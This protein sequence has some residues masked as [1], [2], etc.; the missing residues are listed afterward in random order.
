MAYDRDPIDPISK[1][2]MQSGDPSWTIRQGEA[3]SYWM[4][5]KIE[6]RLYLYPIPSSITW[7]D[8]VTTDSTELVTNGDFDTDTDWEKSVDVGWTI[9]GGVANCD[10]TQ[11]VAVNIWQECS[12]LVSGNTY[13]VVF[14]VS[15]YVAGNVRVRLGNTGVGTYRSAD[16][17]YT[18]TVTAS[19]TEGTW[20]IYMQGDADF[21]GDIDDLSVELITAPYLET[22]EVEDPDAADYASGDTIDVDYNLLVVMD[23]RPTDM[24][25]SSDAPYIKDYIAKYLRYDVIANAYRTNTDGKIKSLAD[26]WDARAKIGYEA[27]KLYLSNRMQDRDYRLEMR[28]PPARQS[29]HPRLPDEYPV[30]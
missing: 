12:S 15:N 19:T 8:S 16:G 1:R 4:D 9:A 26:Y 6:R 7:Q 22:D 5:D 18:E 2:D 14:T 28:T 27:L 17:T 10:G 23:Q 3:V 29:R 21:S 25:Q 11:S 24:E 20:Y 13:Q 30:V